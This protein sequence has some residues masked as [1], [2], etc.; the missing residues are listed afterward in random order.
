MT[1]TAML[2]GSG[3]IVALLLAAAWFTDVLPTRPLRTLL[4]PSH[5]CLD[6]EVT[7]EGTV[8]DAMRHNWRSSRLDWVQIEARNRCP[9]GV[10]FDVTFNV[11]RAFPIGREGESVGIPCD[12]APCESPQTIPVPACTLRPEESGVECAS[13]GVVLEQLDP[14]LDLDLSN[15]DQEHP[16]SL[17][18]NVHVVENG[19]SAGDTGP[20][21]FLFSGGEARGESFSVAVELRPG[22]TYLWEW[23]LNNNPRPEGN[24]REAALA[25]LAVWAI[26]GLVDRRSFA[27]RW[28]LDD[29]LDRWMERL[30]GEV[31]SGL[32]VR[33]GADQLPPLDGDVVIE[34]PETVL[35]EM[36]GSPIEAALLVATLASS[37]IREEDRN[38]HIIVMMA[39]R[40][41]EQSATDVF[42]AWVNAEDP[43]RLM[44]FSPSDAGIKEFALATEEARSALDSLPV[45]GILAELNCA[46]CD[47]VYVDGEGRVAA[48]N[49]IRTASYFGL[50]AGLPLP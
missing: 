27:E 49:I 23:D 4:S 41:E 5:S 10:S 32:R 9:E 36:Q 17:E 20:F 11:E 44:A 25:S 35:A 14:L 1:L 47:G 13:A 28:P 7:A 21:D 40:N 42:V 24:P 45:A 12:G 43:E 50:H 22:T 46:A 3:S 18:F 2:V 8:P 37:V 31:L 38:D 39:P 15:W 16:L 34:P 33:T 26:A 48:V 19:T 6:F 29:S 30:Y